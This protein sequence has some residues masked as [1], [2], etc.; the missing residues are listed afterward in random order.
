VTGTAVVAVGGTAVV[1]GT[2]A[3]RRLAEAIRAA[4]VQARALEAVGAEGCGRVPRPGR[5][6]LQAAVARRARNPREGPTGAA[7]GETVGTSA[8]CVSA[9]VGA[10]PLGLGKSRARVK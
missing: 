2:A 8:C 10:A 4:L 1:T 7:A 9:Q 3:P 5:P 6:T